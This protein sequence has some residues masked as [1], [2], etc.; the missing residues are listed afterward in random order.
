MFKKG[1]VAACRGWGA[2]KRGRTMQVLDD[3]RER[4]LHE[5]GESAGSGLKTRPEKGR[6]QFGPG[7]IWLPNRQT[8]VSWAKIGRQ[9]KMGGRV[10][11]SRTGNSEKISLTKKRVKREG[12]W[13]FM[14]RKK[15]QNEGGRQLGRKRI[16]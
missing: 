12:C 14:S 5:G 3:H 16:H 9:W 8:D 1:E 2:N 4:H 10:L 15:D 13:R 6:G 11:N 7:V